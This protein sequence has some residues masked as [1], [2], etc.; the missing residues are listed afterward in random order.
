MYPFSF[1]IWDTLLQLVLNCYEVV[2]MVAKGGPFGYVIVMPYTVIN[3]A[4]SQWLSQWPLTC[5]LL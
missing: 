3:K 2:A 5:A 1:K 4:V